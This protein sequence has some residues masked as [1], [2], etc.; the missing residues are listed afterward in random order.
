MERI[1]PVKDPLKIIAGPAAVSAVIIFLLRNAFRRRLMTRAE[2]MLGV[3]FGV[4]TC[5][6]GI[7]MSAGPVPDWKTYYLGVGNV[8]ACT[9][10]PD[11][12]TVAFL[13]LKN[14]QVPETPWKDVYT[15][16]LAV[17]DFE[18]GKTEEKLKWDY[19]G[20]GRGDSWYFQS[21]YIRYSSDGRYLVV[22]D[23]TTIRVLDAK[24]FTEVKQIAYESPKESVAFKG[25]IWEMVGLSL[26]S[27]GSRAAVAISSSAGALGG[28][29]RVYDLRTGRILREWRLH[30]GV[31]YVTGVALSADGERVATS[32]LPVGR[33]SEPEA[34]IP[35]G[36]QNVRVLDVKSG[37]MLTGVN[38][39]YVAGPVLFGPRD[40]LLTSSINADR[41]GYGLDSIKV[42]DAQTGKL[43]REI[44]N[45]HAGVHYRL[46]LS[47]DGKLL[48][49]YTGT[50]KA[51]ENLVNID[52]Q[53]FQ[54]WDFTSG[55]V[56]ATSPKFGPI[57][58][59]PPQIQ[60]SPDGRFVVVWWGDGFAMP[61]V[62]EVPQR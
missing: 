24:S 27:D 13:Y 1:S 62:Y 61:L 39:N 33:S 55:R 7:A 2:V 41:K 28:F 10:T 4:I 6:V 31:L 54:V 46:D 25:D 50:E 56:I 11:S 16:S 18:T 45:P 53:Q 30:D 20:A 42:W 32:S 51:V 22:L 17:W 38:T 43:L 47:A 40:T 19:T 44:T 59:E 5:P 15:S 52:T 8:R 9:F 35:S 14:H 21:R 60:L 36:V 23:P 29:I 3:I 37:E 34:F 26:T 49:G 12:Q 58:L 48:V 57:K